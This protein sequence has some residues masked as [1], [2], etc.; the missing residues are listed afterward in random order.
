MQEVLDST[1]ALISNWDTVYAIVPASMPPTV[2]QEQVNRSKCFASIYEKHR[3][4][5]FWLMMC[6]AQQVWFPIESCLFQ[7]VR[8]VTPFKEF[9]SVVVLITGFG[10]G[11]RRGMDHAIRLLGGEC[12]PAAVPTAVQYLLCH[13]RERS[14][15][16]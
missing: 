14:G 1:R 6:R 9:A 13:A 12:A 4:T 5:F 10:D 2:T 16:P 11:V 3:L 15:S 8:F 7:P